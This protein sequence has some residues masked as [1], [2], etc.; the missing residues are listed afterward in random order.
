MVHQAGNSTVSFA[1]RGCLCVFERPFLV[2]FI[3]KISVYFLEILAAAPQI[4]CKK[5]VHLL[6]KG[7]VGFLFQPFF[8]FEDLVHDEPVPLCGNDFLLQQ[9]VYFSHHLVHVYVFLENDVLHGRL[10][11]YFAVLP[12]YLESQ[13]FVEEGED[14]FIVLFIL[15]YN[16]AHGDVYFSFLIMVY[17]PIHGTE[18]LIFALLYHELFPLVFVRK[19]QHQVFA[20]LLVE[21]FEVLLVLC[22]IF[23]HQSL[24]ELLVVARLDERLPEPFRPFTQQHD[25]VADGLAHLLFFFVFLVGVELG[26][27][28][29]LDFL[30]GSFVVVEQRPGCLFPEDKEQRVYFVQQFAQYLLPC[31]EDVFLVGLRFFRHE[32]SETGGET[33]YLFS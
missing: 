5:A 18:K 15:V 9:V 23:S 14:F 10:I 32:E 12:G 33:V 7:P 22:L 21:C 24:V 8:L 1:A 4:G 17:F 28:G 30:K 27:F 26:F 11:L 29:V 25:D 31:A 20:V 13:H 2:I 19:L 6:H 16:M 3:L